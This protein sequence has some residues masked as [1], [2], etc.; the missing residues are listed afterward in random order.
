[1]KKITTLIAPL[2]MILIGVMFTKDY[3]FSD[4]NKDNIKKFESLIEKG[5][6]TTAILGEEYEESTTKIAGVKIKTYKVNYTFKVGE[7]EIQ[8]EETLNNLP[9]SLELDVTYNPED[10]SNSTLGDPKE[11]LQKAKESEESSMGLW[12]GLGLFFGGIGLGVF[13]LKR[14]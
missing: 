5:V 4:V 7:K 8:A 14:A 9:E 6:K 11:M 2:A 13:R 1:M 3:F 12:M 10:P